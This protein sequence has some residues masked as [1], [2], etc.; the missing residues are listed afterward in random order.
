VSR[1]RILKEWKKS[2]KR[3]RRHIW[4]LGAVIGFFLLATLAGS[5]LAHR[6]ITK[7]LPSIFLPA[8]AAPV[9]MDNLRTEENPSSSKRD[10]TL[11]ALQRW[12]GQVELVLHRTYLCGEETRQLGMHSTSEAVDLLKSHR[13]WGV[14][15]DSTGRVMMEQTVDDL[16]PQCRKTAYIGMDKD[17]N[18]SLF[19]GLPRREKVI[20]TFFQLDVEKLESRLSDDRV[21]ELERGIRVT[22]K[23]EYN[24]V[25]STFNDFARLRSQGVLLPEN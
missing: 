15:F 1:F 23:D 2:L 25:L 5:W 22:D 19:D 4:S 11:H 3:K 20:R 8:D 12:Q 21:Q 17:G 9:W 24:S 6:I 18:L 7:S 10:K 14:K 16:S 13:E